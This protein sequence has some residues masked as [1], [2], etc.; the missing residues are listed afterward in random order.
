MLSVYSH[1]IIFHEL[2]GFGVFKEN[3]ALL[4]RVLRGLFKY[5]C[6]WLHNFLHIYATTKW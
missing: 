6:K 4:V 2:Y 3:V 5:E 1:L